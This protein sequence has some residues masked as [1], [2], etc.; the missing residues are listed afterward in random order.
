MSVSDAE[1][2]PEAR[3]W[4]RVNFSETVRGYRG[5]MTRTSIVTYLNPWIAKREKERQQRVEELRRRDG[6]SCRRCR[7]P[8]RFDLPGG[9]D[10]APKLEQIL[11]LA[12]GEA[13]AL[14]NLC[15]CHT[16]CNGDSGDSTAEVLERVQRAVAED[17]KVDTA[18]LSIPPPPRH[19]RVRA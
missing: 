17:D 18:S 4:S 16:R 6:D 15:L 12:N 1:Q 9:H 8:M 10:R 2:T 14:D 3:Q 19:K 7:R 5:P 11:P 13:T